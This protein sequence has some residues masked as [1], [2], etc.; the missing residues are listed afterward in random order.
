MVV[1]VD[2]AHAAI[3]HPQS[4]FEEYELRPIGVQCHLRMRRLLLLLLLSGLLCG[5]LRL[6][7][8]RGLLLVCHVAP[9]HLLLLRHHLG[10]H[11]VLSA[12]R[13]VCHHWWHLH[14]RALG[15]ETGLAL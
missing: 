4:A 15:W 7:R 8:L 11:G 1:K 3:H 14:V 10:C 12:V 5:R 6:A 13:A 9:P 2:S